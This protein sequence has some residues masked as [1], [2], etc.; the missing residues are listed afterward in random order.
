VTINIP[1]WLLWLIGVPLGI[2]GI[3]L[4]VFGAIMMYALK[5]GIYK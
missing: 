1:V 2:I 5:D 3:L 4:A